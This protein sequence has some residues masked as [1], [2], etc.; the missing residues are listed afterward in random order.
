MLYFTGTLVLTVIPGSVSAN[1]PLGGYPVSTIS[2]EL[3]YVVSLVSIVA[4]VAVSWGVVRTQMAQF[5]ADMAELK[6]N[7]AETK[8]NSVTREVL[9][10]RLLNM[11]T[12]LDTMQK[13]IDKI[14]DSLGPQ[15]H[16]M[17]PHHPQGG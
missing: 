5:K 12:K 17:I 13:S 16:L 10:L 14:A 8:A 2:I 11:D 7:L 4:S 6:A 15:A 9:D 1:I 3:P